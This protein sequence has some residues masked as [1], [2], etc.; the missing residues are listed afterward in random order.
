MFSKNRKKIDLKF[1]RFFPSSIDSSIFIGITHRIPSFLRWHAR[2]IQPD[3]H[4]H[5]QERLQKDFWTTDTLTSNSCLVATWN[6]LLPM[7]VLQVPLPSV[8][9]WQRSKA[10]FAGFQEHCQHPATVEVS[11]LRQWRMC[12]A[13]RQS[14]AI[15]T[16]KKRFCGSKQR[17]NISKI[18]STMQN[19]PSACCQ[20][21][22][23]DAPDA[24]RPP[25]PPPPLQW[26]RWDRW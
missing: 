19:G 10:L 13:I 21:R 20:P 24:Q 11:I 4:L 26:R 18:D 9:R 1:L 16:T 6:W 3:L 17:M 25:H 23:L 15:H 7:M 14:V 8:H 22:N 5:G 12:A 2:N